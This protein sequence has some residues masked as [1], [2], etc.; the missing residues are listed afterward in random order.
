MSDGIQGAG[1]GEGAAKSTGFQELE[2][3]LAFTQS[4]FR[5][6]FT[7]RQNSGRLATM[8]LTNILAE[9]DTPTGKLKFLVQMVSCMSQQML[10]IPPPQ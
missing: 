1:R 4:C 5:M 8:H 9:L 2:P 10:L 7:V 3:P 6:P